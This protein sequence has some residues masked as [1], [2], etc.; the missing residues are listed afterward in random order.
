MFPENFP[1]NKR[2]DI[3]D[4]DQEFLLSAMS[5][6]PRNAGYDPEEYPDNY[7]KFFLFGDQKNA[8]PDEIKIYNKIGQAYGTLTETAYITNV[9]KDVE[10]FLSATVLVNKNGIFNDDNY[11][12]ETIAIPFFAALSRQ[13]YELEIERKK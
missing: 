1:E 9:A 3:D 11:E 10:F 8:I 13:I 2:F 12:Y 7:V 5:Q 4:E 6:L